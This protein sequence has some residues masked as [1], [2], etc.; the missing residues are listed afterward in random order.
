MGDFTLLIVCFVAMLCFGLGI[1]ACVYIGDFMS[2]EDILYEVRQAEEHG[3]NRA[4]NTINYALEH[5]AKGE[6][7]SEAPISLLDQQDMEPPAELLMAHGV[8]RMEDLPEDVRTI[9]DKSTPS[10]T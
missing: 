3:Y 10:N 2:Q 8:R 1:G 6:F 7:V 5:S 4:L 9:W